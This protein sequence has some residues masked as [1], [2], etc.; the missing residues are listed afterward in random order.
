LS[1]VMSMIDNLTFEIPLI[2]LAE[3]SGQTNYATSRTTQKQDDD[4]LRKLLSFLDDAITRNIVAQFGFDDIKYGS[5]PQHMRDEKER[6]ELA[7]QKLELGIWEI[8]D[9]RMEW[10]EDPMEDGDISWWYWSEREKAQGMAEG[11]AA[12]SPMMPNPTGEEGEDAQNTPGDQSDGEAIQPPP[13]EP[14]QEP[15]EDDE[16]EI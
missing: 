16:E 1:S 2:K 7:K 6:L 3:H 14:Q 8:N 5:D 10:G 12:G 11:Q 4:G 13:E 9:G 15:V